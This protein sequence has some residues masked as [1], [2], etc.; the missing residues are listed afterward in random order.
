MSAGDCQ[1]NNTKIN[2]KL[3]QITLFIFF[4]L[5][6]NAPEK[7]KTVFRTNICICAMTKYISIIPTD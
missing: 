6:R 2:F 4:F 7:I 1:V 5:S 3:I